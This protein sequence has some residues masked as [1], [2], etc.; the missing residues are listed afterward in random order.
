VVHWDSHL[1]EVMFRTL[2]VWLCCMHYRETG[3]VPANYVQVL[4]GNGK[5]TFAN[6]TQQLKQYE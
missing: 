1:I 4:S 2:S 5:E 6:L 3:Y